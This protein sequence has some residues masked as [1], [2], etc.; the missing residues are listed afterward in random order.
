[1]QDDFIFS[2]TIKDN[3]RLRNYKISD[4]EIKRAAELVNADKFIQ[5]LPQGYDQ[6]VKERGANLSCGELQL[7]SFA[8]AVATNPKILILDE[9]TREIDSETEKLIQ[10]AIVHLLEGRTS[11]VIAHRLSTIKNVDRIIVLHRG[12]IIEEGTHHELLKKGGAYKTLY[13]LQYK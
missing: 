10:D 12:E 6:P 11:I 13:E 5:R 7:L 2:G 4:A 1:S 9:A 3:I 8:R